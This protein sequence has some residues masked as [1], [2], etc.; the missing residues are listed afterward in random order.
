MG[1]ERCFIFLQEVGRRITKSI[2]T[3]LEKEIT[4][5][6]IAIIYSQRENKK[7]IVETILWLNLLCIYKYSANTL[8]FLKGILIP[9][10]LFHRRIK[11][12][13]VLIHRWIRTGRVLNLRSINSPLHM[14]SISSRRPSFGD[15]INVT[16]SS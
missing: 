12:G 14:N 3:M 4:I 9:W 11:N 8:W 13:G 5:L 15:D 10:V 1:N 6:V 2:F 7:K 16:F